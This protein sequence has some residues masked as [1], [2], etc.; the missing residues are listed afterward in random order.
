MSSAFE[1]HYEQM[2]ELTPIT[3]ARV[4]AKACLLYFKHYSNISKEAI[5]DDP[6]VIYANDE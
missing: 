6:S 5:L 1:L 2:K 3:V 4:V